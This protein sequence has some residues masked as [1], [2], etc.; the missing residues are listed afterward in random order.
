[1]SL[2]ELQE[3]VVPVLNIFLFNAQNILPEKRVNSFSLCK[4][5]NQQKIL[6]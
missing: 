1:M 5:N 4:H 6:K 3:M 2:L